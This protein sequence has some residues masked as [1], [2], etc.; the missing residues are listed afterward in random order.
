MKKNR[1]FLKETELLFGD[2]KAWKKIAFIIV[3]DGERHVMP[4]RI[5]VDHFRKL[6]NFEYMPYDESLPAYTTP[7]Q[8]VGIIMFMMD[9]SYYERVITP[10]DDNQELFYETWDYA[11]P[12]DRTIPAEA[13]LPV[14]DKSVKRLWTD[15]YETWRESLKE[16]ISARTID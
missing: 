2:K 9:G 4:H 15:K 16:D 6:A 10:F 7:E 8:I 13:R 11:E 12:P 14:D 3:Y 5:S 1:N